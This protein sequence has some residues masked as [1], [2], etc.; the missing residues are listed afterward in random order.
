MGATFGDKKV[1]FRIQ[2][3]WKK[4]FLFWIQKV[5]VGYKEL[6]GR[7]QRSS[8]WGHTGLFGEDTKGFP[9]KHFLKK[10]VP[11]FSRESNEVFNSFKNCF[12][13]KFTHTKKNTRTRNTHKNTHK[14]T[15]THKHSETNTLDLKLLRPYLLFTSHPIRCFVRELFSKCACAAELIV[16]PR[17]VWERCWRVARTRRESGRGFRSFCT[18]SE[19][20]KGTGVCWFAR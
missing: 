20:A 8:W 18:G 19:L 15:Q 9:G 12:P 11:N 17:R 2:R 7:T 10:N 6:F 14:H 13:H 3:S 1:F 4:G 16:Q 5:F